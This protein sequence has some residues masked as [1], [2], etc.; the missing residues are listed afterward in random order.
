M[1]LAG[2]TLRAEAIA[3]SG[4]FRREAI[5]D[6]KVLAW[7]DGAPGAFEGSS[8][9]NVWQQAFVDYYGKDIGGFDVNWV[10]AVDHCGYREKPKPSGGWILEVRL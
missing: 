1:R 3:S 7:I 10:L 4:I 2:G 6:P 5:V 9:F 8:I